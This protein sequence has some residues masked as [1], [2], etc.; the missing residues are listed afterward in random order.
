[1]SYNC[2]QDSQESLA[3]L[4]GQG[5]SLVCEKGRTNTNSGLHSEEP[6][7][8]SAVDCPFPGITVGLSMTVVSGNYVNFRLD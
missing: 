8:I 6:K 3:S 7:E 1:M 5:Q 4:S 2:L